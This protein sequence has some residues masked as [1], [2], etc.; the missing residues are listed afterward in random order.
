MALFVL[1]GVVLSHTPCLSSL[2]FPSHGLT[3]IYCMQQVQRWINYHHS[4]ATDSKKKKALAVYAPLFR[5][6]HGKAAKKP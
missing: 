5:R 1:V 4:V 3:L 6:L 2:I